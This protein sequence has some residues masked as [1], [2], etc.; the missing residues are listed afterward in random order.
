MD[1][2]DRHLEI[3]K[4]LLDEFEYYFGRPVSI[5]RLDNYI[6]QNKLDKDSEISDILQNMSDEELIMIIEEGLDTEISM[7]RIPSDQVCCSVHDPRF[8]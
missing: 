3:S 4:T 6:R 5:G 7:S 8:H 2:R 1:Y